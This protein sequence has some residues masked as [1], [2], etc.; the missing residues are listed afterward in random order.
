MQAARWSISALILAL[1]A[2]CAGGTDELNTQTSRFISTGELLRNT[3]FTPE[4]ELPDV[5]RALL[6]GLTVPSLEAK[7]EERDGLAYLIPFHTKTVPGLGKINTWTTGDGSQ[8]VL[9]SGVIVA[10]R[11]LGDD[12]TSSDKRGTIAFVTGRGGGNWPLRLDIQTAADGVIR[13]DFVCT[14]TRGGIQ[15]IEIVELTYRVESLSENCTSANGQRIT[16][17]YWV[18]TR[19]GTVWQT[20]Q[21]AGAKIGYID[22]RILK[23]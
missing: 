19:D 7:V 2:G 18:D 4:P 16:N 11:G 5:T 13:Q 23:K 17:R 3:L 1:V 12:M 8:L 9:R 21:W 6:D 22:T 20:R 10:T 14:G 15:S